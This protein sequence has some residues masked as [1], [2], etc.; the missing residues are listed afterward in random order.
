MKHVCKSS[1]YVILLVGV[2][3]L[4]SSSSTNESAAVPWYRFVQVD[5]AADIDDT[6]LLRP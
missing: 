2:Y 4:E 1:A 6:Q 5:A 3:T